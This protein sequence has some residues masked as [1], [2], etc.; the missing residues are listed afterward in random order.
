M[1]ICPIAGFLRASWVTALSWSSTK[2]EQ[3]TFFKR[4]KVEDRREERQEK[5]RRSSGRA[6]LPLVA[7]SPPFYLPY[8]LYVPV[9][10]GPLARGV[11]PQVEAGNREGKERDRLCR[12]SQVERG[13][14]REGGSRWYTKE[15]VP[16]FVSAGPA[17]GWLR[18]AFRRHG[19]GSGACQEGIG[20]VLPHQTARNPDIL[21]PTDVGSA[22][23]SHT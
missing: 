6:V 4:D 15:D 22:P 18:H 8:T 9:R 11:I 21:R 7:G 3:I 12:G 2:A 20:S 17:G 10:S 1:E 5:E 23:V 16:S 13:W 14:L 19:N